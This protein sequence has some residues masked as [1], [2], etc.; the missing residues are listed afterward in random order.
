MKKQVEIT[1]LN[2]DKLVLRKSLVVEIK[3]HKDEVIADFYDGQV[4]GFGETEQ[5]AMDDLK[6]DLVALYHD[7]TE[8]E[9]N[10]GPLPKKWLATLR[11]Y[12]REK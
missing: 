9:E 1:S 10:L 7:L 2:H 12:V 3:G 6:N 4:V 5:E 8:D 11:E